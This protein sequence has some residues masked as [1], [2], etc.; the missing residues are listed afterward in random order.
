M[1]QN[2]PENR[3]RN[4]VSHA[5]DYFIFTHLFLL[6]INCREDIPASILTNNHLVITRV[7]EQDDAIMPD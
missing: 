5:I 1:F 2:F 4:Q 3:T 6:I 7:E